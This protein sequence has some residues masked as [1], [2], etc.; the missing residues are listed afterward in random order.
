VLLLLLLLPFCSAQQQQQ[1]VPL[2]SFG[3]LSKITE[4]L[5]VFCV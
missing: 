3:L 2:M 1:R 4:L 5:L